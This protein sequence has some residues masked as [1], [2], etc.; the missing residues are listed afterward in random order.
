MKKSIISTGLALAMLLG[1]AGCT[2]K[3]Q[4]NLTPTYKSR[5]FCEKIIYQWSSQG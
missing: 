3:P 4:I 1:M 2:S 5:G